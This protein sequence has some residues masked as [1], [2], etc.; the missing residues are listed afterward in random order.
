M[1]DLHRIRELAGIKENDF[2]QDDSDFDG[3]QTLWLL[4]VSERHEGTYFAGI[5][6]SSEL[7]WAA[8]EKL[9]INNVSRPDVTQVVLDADPNMKYS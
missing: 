1:A 4:E 9:Q 7:A 8:A 2:K 5:Y 6:S 3:T